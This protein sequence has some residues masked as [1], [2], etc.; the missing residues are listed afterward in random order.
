MQQQQQQQQQR[1]DGQKSIIKPEAFGLA[2]AAQEDEGEDD[3][4]Q[5]GVGSSMLLIEGLR[6]DVKMNQNV[7]NKR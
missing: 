4:P 1:K 3:E 2:H 6:G 7:G 5:A